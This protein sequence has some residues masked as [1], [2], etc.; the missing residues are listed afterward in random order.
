MSK[1]KQEKVFHSE[2][3]LSK[4]IGV[5]I[6]KITKNLSKYLPFDDILLLDT[7]QKAYKG[8]VIVEKHSIFEESEYDI[9]GILT[10]VKIAESHPYFSLNS[11]YLVSGNYTFEIDNIMYDLAEFKMCCSDIGIPLKDITVA[12][13]NKNDI[14]TQPLQNE[15]SRLKQKIQDLESSKTLSVNDEKLLSLINSKHFPARISL[16]LEAYEEFWSKEPNL[17]LENGSFVEK[18]II[19][20]SSELGIL[21][22]SASSK[23][24]LKAISEKQ[25]KAIV[26]LIKPD[27]ADK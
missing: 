7:K 26:T 23:N 5:D 21:C 4:Y 15:I 24:Y 8:L 20:R 13:P 19:K 1:V 11:S 10:Q 16:I 3:E 14:Y 12:T 18:W 6:R 17:D 9:R 25:A 27:A 2:F 22:D